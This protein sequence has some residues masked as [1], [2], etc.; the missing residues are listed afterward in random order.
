M[1]EYKVTLGPVSLRESQIKNLK[2]VCT[3][4]DYVEITAGWNLEIPCH[5]SLIGLVAQL[6]TD[7]TVA[8]RFIDC[9]INTGER[10][11]IPYGWKSPAIPASTTDY[12]QLNQQGYFENITPRL[13]ANV[14]GIG[15]YGGP[16]AGNDRI[17]IYTATG[18]A[19]DSLTVWA[20]FLSLDYML[21]ILKPE[22]FDNKE[23]PK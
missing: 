11:M 2:H 8:N 10:T 20:Q 17:V 15:L 16:I 13:G 1:I 9:Y 21:G 7:A 14:A 6:T 23:Y 4:V 5:W 19:G 3:G 18:K 12:L 22:Q